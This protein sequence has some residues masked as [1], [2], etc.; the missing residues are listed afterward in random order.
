MKFYAVDKAGNEADVCTEKYTIDKTAPALKGT[1]PKNNAVNIAVDKAIKV[2]FSEPIKAGSLWIEFKNSAGK[3]AAF[4][5]SISGNVLTITP[6]SNLSK[7]TMYTL[8]IHSG[9]VTDLS[10]NK[11]VYAGSITFKTI[12]QTAPKVAAICPTNGAT[13]ISRTRTISIRLSENILKS[14]NWS[15]VYIKNLKTGQKCK[16][17]ACISGNHI[18]IKTSSKRATY[19]WYQVYIPASAVKDS[20]GNNLA[21]AYTFKFRTGRY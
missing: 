13:G 21:K 10:G 12:D 17:T 19:T 18:Y 6:T 3:A 14:V 2:T 9:S 20:A 1:D 7:E 4:T 15:K 16:I 5:T 11:Y 8:I